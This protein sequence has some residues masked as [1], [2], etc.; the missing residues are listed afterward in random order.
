M[1][2]VVV[3]V[4]VVVVVVT[5]SALR[6]CTLSIISLLCIG[7]SFAPRRRLVHLR[8]RSSLRAPTENAFYFRYLL[9]G[10]TFVLASRR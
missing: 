2:V 4:A 7:F 6:L 10:G 1:V 3:I 8:S 5:Y 9:P